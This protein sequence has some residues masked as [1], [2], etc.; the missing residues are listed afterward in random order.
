M[1]Q[2]PR[3]WPWLH[4]AV[5][6]P[7]GPALQPLSAQIG[8]AV[9]VLGID[10]VVLAMGMA[11]V[12]VSFVLFNLAREWGWGSYRPDGGASEGARPSGR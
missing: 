11:S 10:Y 7:P 3:P 1:G 5:A 2:L 6:V 4:A 12:D 8:P 9:G